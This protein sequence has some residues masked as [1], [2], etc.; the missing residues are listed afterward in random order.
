[1]IK[2]ALVCIAMTKNKYTCIYIGSYMMLSITYSGRKTHNIYVIM[3]MFDMTKMTYPHVC[4]IKIDDVN[5]E[6]Y[7]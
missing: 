5:L 1:L 3:S 7:G 6:R 4:V 2:D